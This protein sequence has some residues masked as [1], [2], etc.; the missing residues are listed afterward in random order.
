MTLGFSE[1]SI[2]I[3]RSEVFESNTRLVRL[4]IAIDDV[5]SEMMEA[6][7]GKG[8]AAKNL[9]IL[10]IQFLHYPI[11]IS[12]F[13]TFE[14]LLFRF[15]RLLESQF[16]FREIKPFPKESRFP[17]I[18]NDVKSFLKGKFFGAEWTKNLF[19]ERISKSWDTLLRYQELR[20]L[21]TH[22]NG[23]WEGLSTPDRDKFQR[24]VDKDLFQFHSSGFIE[25]K[26]GLIKLYIET[27]FGFLNDLIDELENSAKE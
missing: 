1:L 8:D 20:N 3:F 27:L 14:W 21:L 18:K 13:S 12:A 17:D 7:S 16:D 11:L 5:I 25:L 24:L 19:S 10:E 23:Y 2:S 22:H 15:C 6:D 9:T 4:S 26:E